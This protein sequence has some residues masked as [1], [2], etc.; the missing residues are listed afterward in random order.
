MFNE[1]IGK[2]IIISFV[3]ILISRLIPHPPNFT[4]AISVAFYLPAL[5]GYK[6]IIVS[7]TAFILSDLLIG[8]HNLLLFTWGSIIFIGLFSRYFKNLYFRFLGI[9]GSCIIFFLIS[10]LGV[11][12]MSNNY[13]NNLSGLLT[14]YIMGLPFLKNSLISSLGISVLVE[15]FI[16][17]QFAKAYILKINKNFIY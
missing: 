4:T 7:L 10:N 2:F 16:S 17:M 11:W 3:S 15:F 9:V 13:E 14:C 1:R 12:L 5:F 8:V 6:Y